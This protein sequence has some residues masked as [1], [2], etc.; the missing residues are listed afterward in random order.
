M[1]TIIKLKLSKTLKKKVLKERALD[2]ARQQ[3]GF[4]TI[5]EAAKF[6]EDEIG[7]V[8]MRKQLIAAV[9]SGNIMPYNPDTLQGYKPNVVRDFHE[10]ILSED[11]NKWFMDT[12]K[13]LIADGRICMFPTPNKDALPKTGQ[14]KH[15][16]EIKKER[17]NSLDHLID[18]AIKLVGNLENSDVFP[19]LKE[20]ALN[21]RRPFTGEVEGNSLCYTNDNDLP[22][23][24]TKEA[25]GKR[26]KRR[27]DTISTR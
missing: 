1:A 10:L 21:E 27:K 22:A 14:P 13:G 17:R 4:Y 23:K 24:L 12:Q 19:A 25:L 6:I 2:K 20:M 18:E 16:G 7:V 8:D 5:S 9:K 3:K 26:L 11:L 15:S